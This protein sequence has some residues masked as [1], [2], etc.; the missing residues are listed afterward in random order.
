MYD[1][2]LTLDFLRNK[3]NQTGSVPPLG[4]GD[5]F[6]INVFIYLYSPQFLVNQIILESGQMLQKEESAFPDTA[7]I[8]H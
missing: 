2:H 5:P 3:F 4:L 1:L 8:R 7:R 6:K